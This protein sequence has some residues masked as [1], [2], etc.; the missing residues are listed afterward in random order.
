MMTLET[1]RALLPA[2]PTADM[3]AAASPQVV[4]VANHEITVFVES[5]PLFDSMIRDIMAAKRR[6]WLETYIFYNDEGGTRIAEALK[7][8]AREGLDVRVHYDALGAAATPGAF[9]ADM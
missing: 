8:K 3:P 5:P 4:T 6:V 1:P 9:F 2:P 7:A